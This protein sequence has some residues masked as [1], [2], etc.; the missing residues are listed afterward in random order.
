MLYLLKVEKQ[1]MDHEETVVEKVHD[2]VLD[3]T[4]TGI[5]DIL[6]LKGSNYF[7]G[8]FER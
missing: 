5:E 1:D 4:M 2:R 8:G 6:G 7:R 3:Y